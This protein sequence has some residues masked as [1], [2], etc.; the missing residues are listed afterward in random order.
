NLT[1]D[2]I[3]LR[4]NGTEGII[5]KVRDNQRDLFSH[6][7]NSSHLQVKN[8][9]NQTLLINDMLLSIY[10]QHIE[11]LNQNNK[12]KNANALFISEHTGDPITGKQYYTKFMK[13]KEELLKQLSHEENVEDY[14][15]LSENDWSTHIGRGDFITILLDISFN[16]M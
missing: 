8:P 13:V 6:I 9:R 5:L 15:L 16:L 7:K 10:R 2:R 4:G 1:R 14:L 11:W 3:Q 12:I